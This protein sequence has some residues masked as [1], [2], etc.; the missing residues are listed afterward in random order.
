MHTRQKN[1][2]IVYTTDDGGGKENKNKY[3]KSFKCI[4]IDQICSYV[5]NKSV[6]IYP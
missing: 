3:G 1:Q 2:N 6:R 4:L 5:E